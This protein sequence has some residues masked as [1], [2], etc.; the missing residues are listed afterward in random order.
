MSIKEK[1]MKIKPM[2]HGRAETFLTVGIIV[3]TGLLGFGLG[4][5]SQT[6]SRDFPVKIEE[7]PIF[8]NLQNVSGSSGA[9]AVESGVSVGATGGAVVVGSRNSD[10]YHYPWCSGA[11]RIT[12]TNKVEFTSI[13]EARQAGYQPAGNCPGLE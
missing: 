5:L 12:D 1:I 11:K 6:D 3:L 2:M 13:E 8:Q 7:I 4:Q 10:K 9:S